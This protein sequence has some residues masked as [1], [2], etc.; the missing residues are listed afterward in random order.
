[1]VWLTFWVWCDGSAGARGDLVNSGF[2]T[3][4]GWSY[5]VSKRIYDVLFVHIC[6]HSGGNGFHAETSVG[7]D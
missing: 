4:S 6:A 1:M 5:S 3:D 7:L 2:E